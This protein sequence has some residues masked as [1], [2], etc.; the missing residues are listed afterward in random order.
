MRARRP[1]AGTIEQFY[2]GSLPIVVDNDN[3]NGHFES[4]VFRYFSE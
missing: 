2:A 4:G 3:D 1:G